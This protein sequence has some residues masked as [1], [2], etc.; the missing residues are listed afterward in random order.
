MGLVKLL[1]IYAFTGKGGHMKIYRC[2]LCGN[3][4]VKLVDSGAPLSCCGQTMTEL[5]P[6]KTDAAL[7]KHVPVVAVDGAKVTVSVGEVAHP[8]IET[9]YIQFILL[10]TKKGF[11]MVSLKPGDEPKAEFAV[12]DGDAAVAAYEFCNLHGLWM[13]EI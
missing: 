3:I 13:K 4:V 9:H 8:M 2:E 11:Q 6:N 7:E 5:V 12:A 10:E 1:V